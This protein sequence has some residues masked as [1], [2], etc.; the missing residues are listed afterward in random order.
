MQMCLYC[1][2][3]SVRSGL[4]PSKAVIVCIGDL[5]PKLPESEQPRDI[6][7]YDFDSVTESSISTAM[8]EF[9]QT[10]AQIESSEETN[11]WPSGVDADDNTCAACPIRWSCSKK[12]FPRRY[13]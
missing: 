6:L 1:H 5:N 9:E 12:T 10:I 3:Y 11:T 7:F 2:M 4:K 13:P 8:E